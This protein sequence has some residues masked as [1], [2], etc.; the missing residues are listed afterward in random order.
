[1]T[2]EETLRWLNNLIEGR[3]DPRGDTEIDTALKEAVKIIGQEPCED[4]ISRKA[5]L[6][7][8]YNDLGL[9]DEENGKDVERLMEL[10]SSYRYVKALPS[11]NLQEPKTGHWIDN[12][13]RKDLCNCSECGALSKAYSK[14][15]HNCGAKMVEPQESEEA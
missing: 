14:Y 15:C 3:K 2:R 13:A 5:V 9:G 12:K 4:A 8:I 10:E 6:N 1:M 7:Y 11:V